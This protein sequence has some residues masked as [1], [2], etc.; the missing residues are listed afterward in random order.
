MPASDSTAFEVEH[1]WPFRNWPYEVS[2][3][4]R[5]RRS[6][7]GSNS[8][9]VG[10]VLKPTPDADGYLCVGLSKG[11]HVKYFKVHAMVCECAHGPKSDPRLEARHLDGSKQNN[12]PSNLA[13]GTSKENAADRSDHGMTRRGETSPRA[14]ITNAQAAAIRQRFC[15]ARQ[16][17]QRV[18]KG[19][20]E[21]I[22]AQYGL[23]VHGI[24]TIV[25]GRGYE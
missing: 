19:F 20:R 1:W 22:A 18:P 13:W 3:L 16:G 2:G 11:G 7:P 10:R 8:T 15:E 5:V 4:G 21:T 9:K 24:A 14:K 23:S 12:V 6:Q 25:S 17:R